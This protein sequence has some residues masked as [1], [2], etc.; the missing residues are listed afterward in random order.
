MAETLRDD[1]DESNTGTEHI[2]R[3]GRFRWDLR[4]KALV[5]GI[6]NVTPDS[7]SDGGKF[8]DLDMALAHAH[9]LVL[10]GADIIDIGGE[11]TRPGSL[12]VTK[13]EELFRTIPVIERVRRETDAAISIDTSKPEVA[14]AALQAGADIINDVTGFRSLKMRSLCQSSTCGMVAMHM[15]G[16]PATM[17]ES[18]NYS[19]VVSEVGG[20][21]D[22]LSAELIKSGIHPER[23]VL[24]PG[25][26][27]GKTLDH[28]IALLKN[29]S[30]LAK[31]RRP[32]LMGI[33]KKSLIALL[34]GEDGLEDRHYPTLALTTLTRLHGALIHR[35]HAVPDNCSAL[36][37]VEAV[38]HSTN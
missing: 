18:P 26:G 12:P 30:S 38:N 1:M 36:R 13:E 23:I 19:D 33:S 10:D 25:I 32:L 9:Q 7:F 20:Y 21:F 37:M 14:R 4:E 31:K 17:Q 27:F 8:A 16:T 28:N 34:L 2:W 22:Q 35:V 3:A 11:S 5:M 15:K 24:D 29:L 6:L